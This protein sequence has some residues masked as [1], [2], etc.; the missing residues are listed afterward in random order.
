MG[1]EKARTGQIGNIQGDMK[2]VK[3]IYIVAKLR[4]K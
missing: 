2:I 1:E 4:E 3:Y